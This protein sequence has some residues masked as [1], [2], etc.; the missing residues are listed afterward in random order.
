M[1]G[2]VVEVSKVME[3]SFQ[4]PAREVVEEVARVLTHGGIAVVATD[5]L[6]GIIADA[7]N[8]DAVARVY[9]VKERSHDKPLPIL[10]GESHHAVGLVATSPVFWRLARAFWPGPLTIVSEPGPEAPEHLKKWTGIGVRLPDC[11]L[12]RQV[13]SRLHGA[14]TGTSANLSGAEN[15]LT[16]HQAMSMLGDSVDVYVDTGLVRIGK[17][18]TVVDI[19]RGETRI[20]R[21]GAI[22]AEAVM[23]VIQG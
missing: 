8:E 15:P 23:R 11:P 22:P 20:I 19:R 21:E 12:C 4:C 17:P 14:L 13:A 9:R 7:Y 16:A 3:T 6:Y 5:T 1:T 2:C 10:L 18:S